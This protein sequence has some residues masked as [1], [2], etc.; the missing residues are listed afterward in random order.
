MRLT[1]PKLNVRVGE[2]EIRGIQEVMELEAQETTSDRLSKMGARCEDN[3]G[4]NNTQVVSPITLHAIQS[5]TAIV[6]PCKN[7]SISIMRG[8]W[9]AIPASSLIIVVSGSES[10]AYLEER[11]EFISF[12]TATGRSGLCVHQR[13][14][15]LAS[16]LRAVGMKALLNDDDDGLVF[17]GKGEALVIGIMLAAIAQGPDSLADNHVPHTLGDE[18]RSRC[19][20]DDETRYESSNLRCDNGCL[21]AITDGSAQLVCMS[22]GTNGTSRSANIAGKESHQKRTKFPAYYEYIGFVDADNLVPGS[23]QEYCRAFSAGLALA[24]A[25]DAMVRIR[26][27]SKPKVKDG[28]LEFKQSGRSSE[29]VNRWLNRLLQSMSASTT[30]GV[31][32]TS[33]SEKETDHIC[34]GNAGEHAMSLSLALKLR[35][36][37]GY[38]IEPFHFLDIFERFAGDA[39][40]NNVCA[41]DPDRKM[42]NKPVGPSTPVSISPTSSPVAAPL[43]YFPTLASYDESTSVTLSSAFSSGRYMS[44]I[45]ENH[46]LPAPITIRS[47]TEAAQNMANITPPTTP[48]RTCSASAKV[49]ILQIRTINPHFHEN[50]G[51]EHV[52]RMWQQGLSAIYHSV[53]TTTLTQYREDLRSA[54]FG[55][56]SNNKRGLST[57]PATNCASVAITPNNLSLDEDR[58]VNEAAVK[59]AASW[60]PERCRIYPSAINADLVELRNRL[61]KGKGSLWWN[62]QTVEA[63]GI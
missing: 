26:W 51:E 18:F 62:G 34:T 33:E 15:E 16:A 54:I 22:N 5:R 48:T 24:D 53:L 17:K 19:D 14:P 57:P 6:V 21:D 42:A 49:Q 35:L 10:A 46:K 50:K 25:E 28:K 4:N 32:T 31:E 58:N 2:V 20:K 12:C 43:D 38:A 9:A 56:G 59:A 44:S 23:V 61:A 27:A 60:Q 63:D 1:S 47:V 36:A 11:A 13:D 8:V 7:E 30:M 29:I 37:N 39:N 45:T 55:G 3:Q 40:I 41:T 52:V